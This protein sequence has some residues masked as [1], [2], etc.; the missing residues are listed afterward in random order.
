[1]QQLSELIS[2]RESWLVER[3]LHYAG[4]YGYAPF[5]PTSTMQ[6]AGSIRALSEPLL[7]ALADHQSPPQLWLRRGDVGPDP[8]TQ[9]GI[10]AAL[11]HRSRGVS[12][13]LFLGLLKYY[14]QAYLDVLDTADFANAERLRYREFIDRYFDRIEIGFCSEWCNTNES[15]R[16]LSALDQSRAGC[17]DLTMQQRVPRPGSDQALDVMLVHAGEETRQAVAG[18]LERIGHRVVAAAPGHETV[19][20]L[21]RRSFDLVVMDVAGGH[22]AQAI[23]QIAAFAGPDV[24]A[25]PVVALSAVVT[26]DD[27]AGIQAHGVDAFVAESGRLARLHSALGAAQQRHVKRGEETRATRLPAG[28][29]GSVDT[30]ID[31][32]ML[33]HHAAQ[34]GTAAMQRIVALFISTSHV[35][36]ALAQS[37][38]RQGA[39]E[40]VARAAHRLKSSAS[41]VG[42]FRLADLAAASEEMA[43]QGDLAG[44]ERAVDELSVALPAA[45]A[46]L[47]MAW[48]QVQLPVPN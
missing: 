41:T 5:A 18:L 13:S 19:E 38:L 46:T 12:I 11:R 6:W 17:T 33:V 24:A 43:T 34:L 10:Q 22:D 30:E 14:R 36:L 32:A 48:E 16:V 35:A 7:A 27:L 1:M 42:L 44:L 9:Y 40:Q 23:D 3:I 28:A 8:I 4:L 20:V 15:A 25:L 47:Q 21:G 45:I 31:R 29:A 26:A 37:S 2:R 39:I